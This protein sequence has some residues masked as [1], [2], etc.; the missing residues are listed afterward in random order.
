MSQRNTEV[1]RIPGEVLREVGAIGRAIRAD[2][3]AIKALDDALSRKQKAEARLRELG[4]PSTVS[5]A[6]LIRKAR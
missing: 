1:K 2:Q 4:R 6:E 5:M 3:F